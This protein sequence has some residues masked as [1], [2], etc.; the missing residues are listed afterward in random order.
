M[1]A[2]V[3][4]NGRITSKEE[5]T[6]S[7]YDHGF[8]Y[9]DG[10][11]EGIRVYGGRIFKLEEHLDR[12]Y[13]SARAILLEIPLSRDEMRD[14]IIATVRASGLQDA[15]IRPVVS[16]G[17][18]D[19]GIDPRKCTGATVVIIVDAIR[20]YPKEAYER[21]LRVVTASVRRPAPDALNG[22]VKSLNYLNNILARLE[23]NRAGVEEALLL[24]ADGYLCECSADN[25][26]LVKGG[27]VRTPA[28]HLGLLKGI[29]RDTVL[30]LARQLGIPAEEGILTLHD[31]YTAD[32]CFLTGTGAEVAPVVDADGRMIGD[33]RPGEITRRLNEALR[34]LARRTGTPV[35]AHHVPR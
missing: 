21:G 3:Y 33:G 32:E 24:T 1:T 28:A 2:A 19:L 20:L 22:R 35:G 12:L 26:F 7:V 29:T 9:G 25:I 31:L 5:A 18:G 15:Y 10:V 13:E 6:V 14:A 30:D 4:V 23:A 34:D 27:V 8:L 11:F 16:R 17:P